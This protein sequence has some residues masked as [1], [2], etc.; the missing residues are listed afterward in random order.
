VSWKILKIGF[1]FV[2]AV[3]V[4]QNIIKSIIQRTSNLNNDG[5]PVGNPAGYYSA[6]CIGRG[7]LW[8]AC[9]SVCLSVRDY[10]S[11]T[12]RPIF[13]EF[14]GILPIA[15]AR[16]SSDSVTICYVLPGFM[17]DVIFAH[18]GSYGGM[19]IPFSEWRHCVVIRRLTPCCVVL[20]A[21]RPDDGVQGV[22]TAEPA[23]HYCLVVKIFF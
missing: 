16:S 5:C 22:P 6:S 3:Y 8:W 13:T 12:T 18:N 17:D 20:A 15:V 2:G 7:A 11:G 21:S 10:N 19:S 23:M 14:L 9:Q 4:S 1:T